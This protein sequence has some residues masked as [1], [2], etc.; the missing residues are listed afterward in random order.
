MT[1]GDRDFL[2][3]RLDETRLKIEELLPK[4]DPEKD[5][6][7][8]WTLKLML[9]HITGWDEATVDALRAHALGL[10][11]S[12]P[13]IHSLDEYNSLTVSSRKDWTYDQTLKEWRQTRQILRDIL[14]QLPEEKFIE[15]I[16]VPWGKKTTV[17][18]LVNI[19]SQHE[20]E[21]AQDIIEWLQ[22]PEKPLGKAVK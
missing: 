3:N 17:T 20:K 22:Q 16:A 9:A 7:P 13:A 10:P 21:H 11:P 1:A 8:G 12:I 4:I 5:I 2:L 14:E 18:K 19:F 6:Y 15:P